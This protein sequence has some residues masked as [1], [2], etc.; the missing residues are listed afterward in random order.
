[1]IEVSRDGNVMLGIFPITFNG[2]QARLFEGPVGALVVARDLRRDRFETM[3]A[4]IS[5]MQFGAGL[6]V[7][8]SLGRGFYGHVVINRRLKRVIATTQALA[9][10]Q[11]DARIR[12][13]GNDELSHI[14]NA[15]DEMAAQLER[16]K[17]VLAMGLDQTRMVLERPPWTA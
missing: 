10:G 11:S 6:I 7:L 16:Q 4:E 1:V 15:F 14:A 8:L 2:K 9:A 17:K 13:P 5:N 3:R 12:L